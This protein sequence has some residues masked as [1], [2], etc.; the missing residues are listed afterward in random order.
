M[1][2]SLL[3]LLRGG[4]RRTGARI[5]EKS[6]QAGMDKTR[7]CIYGQTLHGWCLRLRQIRIR[8]SRLQ[9][10]RLLP[11]AQPTPPGLLLSVL[12]A[13]L[14]MAQLMQPGMAF[15]FPQAQLPLACMTRPGMPFSFLLPQFL[16]PQPTVMPCRREPPPVQMAAVLLSL[17]HSTA[18]LL[19]LL[20]VSRSTGT[21]SPTRLCRD[22]DRGPR[23][24]FAGSKWKRCMTWTGHLTTYY[25]QTRDRR[26]R[27][28][29]RLP[30]EHLLR[31]PRRRLRLQ[32]TQCRRRHSRSRSRQ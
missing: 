9:R 12:L 3:E 14:P 22:R 31:R 10:L 23:Q 8:R 19:S 1:L 21:A 5:P 24:A 17:L 4:L 25:R 16:L 2:L 13:Q 18:L 28:R 27:L 7:A 30:T 11:L 32:L 6:L 26:H 15:N 29:V 20:L